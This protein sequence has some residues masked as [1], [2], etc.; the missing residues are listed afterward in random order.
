MNR[1]SVGRRPAAAARQSLSRSFEVCVFLLAG[2]P[3]AI[4]FALPR[5][6]VFVCVPRARVFF[7]FPL[8]GFYGVLPAKSGSEKSRPKL[9]V[10]GRVLIFGLFYLFSV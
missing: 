8:R 3:A 1:L 9:R 4:L 7:R 5:P 2:V 6:C 10:L